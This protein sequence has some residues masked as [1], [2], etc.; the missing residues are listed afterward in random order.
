M[1]R[2]LRELERS[3]SLEEQASWVRARLRAGDLRLRDLRLAAALEVE[4]ARLALGIAPLG[5][6]RT[7]QRLCARLAEVDPGLPLRASLHLCWRVIP[8][9]T[10]HDAG[11]GDELTCYG[12]Q[13]PPLGAPWSS[14]ARAFLAQVQA[15]LDPD[16]E[17][18]RAHP[19][20][21]LQ[22]LSASSPALF[23]G[24]DFVRPHPHVVGAVRALGEAVCERRPRR[25]ARRCAD[26]LHKAALAMAEWELD[27]AQARERAL[28]LLQGHLLPPDLTP[29]GPA[30]G[31]RS[32]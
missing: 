8:I 11:R 14:R 23:L 6:R 25:V 13:G 4:P 21:A 26:S 5:E 9:A 18:Q 20:H 16:V 29:G 32:T 17:S 1:D 27:Y 2:R 30:H 31:P 19:K 15:W 12:P 24:H 7:F 10:A 28:A 22:W 3:S